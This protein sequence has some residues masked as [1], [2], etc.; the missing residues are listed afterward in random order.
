[1]TLLVLCHFVT[2]GWPQRH[3]AL[4]V[5]ITDYHKKRSVLLVKCIVRRMDR[6][7]F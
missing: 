4:P 7:S 2:N 6:W 1:M 5:Q 3:V